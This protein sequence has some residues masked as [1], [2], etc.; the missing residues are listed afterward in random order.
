MPNKKIIIS[1][2]E[3][4]S[5]ITRSEDTTFDTYSFNGN[6]KLADEAN[7]LKVQNTIHEIVNRFCS[8]YENTLILT[9]AGSSIIPD[10][11]LITC[12]VRL[13]DGNNY[14]GK[15]MWT[16][17]DE[18][19]TQLKQ[20]FT[21]DLNNLADLVKYPKRLPEN[22]N[23]VDAFNLEDL[24]TRVDVGREFIDTAVLEEFNNTIRH[25]ESVIRENCTIKMCNAHPHKLFL[26]KLT[27]RKNNY[28]RVKIYTTNYDTL[29]EEAAEDGGF[30]L[31]DGFSFSKSRKFS[32]KYF[33]YDFVERQGSKIPDEPKYISKVVHLLKIHGSIDW[34][35]GTDNNVYKV[36]DTRGSNPL[37][38]YPRRAKFEQSY[39]KPYFELF[40]RFQNDLKQPNTLLMVIGFSFADKHIRSIVE[41]AVKSN[42]GL[43]VLIVDINIEKS[44]YQFF[45][46]RASKFED[47][48]LYSNSFKG[49]VEDVFRKQMAYS[50]DLFQG[51]DRE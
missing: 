48:M 24:L 28:N 7:K 16:L 27:A 44:E 8:Q 49:F 38:I 26:E 32:S 40:S 5:I 25:I 17:R 14:S 36:T 46:E 43:K 13:D 4:V 10:A 3:K 15:S 23:G 12:G 47:V 6:D 51:G 50:D 35:L 37:M 20:S 22:E 29:F 1:S 41:D 21:C 31:V 45:I 19:Q 2:N 33:D 11:E 30:I 18:I 34:E 39:E 9:G 42:P